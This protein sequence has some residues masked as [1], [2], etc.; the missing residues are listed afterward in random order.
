MLVISY[1]PGY[2]NLLKGLKPSTRQRFVALTL[3]YPAPGARTRIVEPKAAATRT[4]SA[5]GATGQALRRLTDHDLEETASTR[6]LVMA[7]RLV[8]GPEPGQCLPRRVLEALT[9]DAPPLPPCRRCSVPCSATEAGHGALRSTGACATQ[10]A[11]FALF[12]AAPALDLLRFDLHRSAAVGAGPPWT[13]GIDAFRA[14][15]A[16]ATDAALGILLRG[17]VPALLLA[18]GVPGRGLALGPRVL[19]LAVPALL[20]GGTAQR[21]AAPRLRR[22]SLW[23]AGATPIGGRQPQRR[24]WPVWAASC[25]AFGGLWSVTLLTYLLPPDE[26]WSGLLHASLT[27]NQTRFIVIG[28]A[29]FTPS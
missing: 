17:I 1:N 6:L 29:L 19:R 2:Q 13:L 25:V 27:P 12:L 16:T 5:P 20:A 18:A 23:D 24:W 21:P 11:F 22:L 28:A 4:G 10:L 15:R 26:I 9:D 14:G 3:G 7:A 8:R